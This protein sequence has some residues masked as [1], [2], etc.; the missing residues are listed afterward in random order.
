L[1]K[2]AIIRP[3]YRHCIDRT[4]P[5]VITPAPKRA[6]EGSYASAG[7]ITWVLLSKYLDHLPLA[8]QQRMLKR[9]GAEI[10]RQTLCNWVE[11]PSFLLKVIY[12]KLLADGQTHGQCVL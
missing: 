1:F 2:R 10:P 9:W 11:A 12:W 3:K 5:P 4:R 6:I 7:L 8:R